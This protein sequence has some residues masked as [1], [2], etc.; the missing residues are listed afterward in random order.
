MRPASPSPKPY[1][2]ARLS[3]VSI[4]AV[5]PS[6]CVI[7][8]G[9]VPMPSASVAGE[10]QPARLP[11]RSIVFYPTLLPFLPVRA[12]QSPPSK[13]SYWLPTKS[14][15]RPAAIRSRRPT[16]VWAFPAGKPQV[17]AD[18]PRALSKGVMVYGF[19]RRLPRWTQSA[20]AAGAG[21]RIASATSGTTLGPRPVCGWTVWRAIRE[22]VR[23]RN[24]QPPLE[25]IHFQSQ[26]G[27]KRSSMLG[28]DRNGTPRLFV[29]GRAWR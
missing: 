2:S 16:R 5:R 20:L 6:S 23:R 25:W 22:E 9:R 27:K 28:L 18:T 11:L 29:V 12:V 4:G 21:S 3:C 7:G 10:A 26:W 24:S 13:T 15:S 8:P 17:F 14:P 1:R 19:G